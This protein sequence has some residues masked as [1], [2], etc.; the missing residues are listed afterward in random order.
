MPAPPQ[1]GV[2]QNAALAVLN[3]QD[4]GGAGLGVLVSLL[5]PLIY[6]AIATSTLY[7]RLRGIAV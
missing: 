7:A 6:A 3:G 4:V 2:D 5:F 1:S